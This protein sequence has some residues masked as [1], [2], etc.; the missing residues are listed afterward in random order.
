[1]GKGTSRHLF[2]FGGLKFDVKM[3]VFYVACFQNCVIGQFTSI[4]PIGD[5]Q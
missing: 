2:P 1:M 4:S 3:V 5:K